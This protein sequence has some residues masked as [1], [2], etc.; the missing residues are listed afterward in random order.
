MSL[1]Q[2]P[3]GLRSDPAEP[4]PAEP[5]TAGRR[6]GTPD[7]AVPAETVHSSGRRRGRPPRWLIKTA[8]PLALVL[9]WQLASTTGALPEETLAAPG[10]IVA[11]AAGLAET[12]ELQDAVLT[13]LSRV[14]AGL[15]IGIGAAVVLATVSGLFRLGEDLID[16]PV[17]MLRTVPTIGL[18]PLLIIWFG[19]GEEPKIALI[20][21]TVTF[22]LYMNIYGGIRNVDSA[23]IEAGRTLGLGRFGTVRHIVLPGAMPSALVGLRYALGSAWLALVFGET[24]NAS[25]GIGYLMN[26]AREFFQTDVIVVC[27]VLYAFLGLLAD[28]IVRVLERVLL[29]WRPAFSGT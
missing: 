9:L 15:G 13:S 1:H 26:N 20:A 4:H 22:P 14:L 6:T 18:I 5:D 23:L 3:A 29:A 7:P 21:L 8:S 25:S 16:A 2:P 24:I 12:G 19:I 27:L 17:Q 10:T 11:T 28:L